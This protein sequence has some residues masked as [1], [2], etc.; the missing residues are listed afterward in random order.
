VI[1]ISVLVILN[2]KIIQKKGYMYRMPEILQKDLSVVSNWNLLK[3]LEGELC[4]KN[5][6]GCKF[7]TFLNKKIYI[8]GDSL[9]GTLIFN[10]KDK[11]TKRGYQYITSTFE[12]C[13][14]FLGTNQINLITN[15]EYSKCNNIYFQR[16]GKKLSDE[17]N[18]IIIFGGSYHFYNDILKG[19]NEKEEQ[20]LNSFRNEILK[21]SKN[22]KIILIYSIPWNEDHIPRKLKVFFDTLP[23]IVIKKIKVGDY[24]T[25][26]YEVY[27]SNTKSSFELLDSIQGDNIYRVYPHTLFCDTIIKKRCVTHDDKN[28][29]YADYNHPSIKGA[30]M[31]NDLIMKEIEKIELKSN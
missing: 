11:V 4:H 28:I 18:S 19:D 5:I 13:L 16:L 17:K 3:N 15:K 25:S 29:F 2:F 30:E 20:I 6:D 21:L 10:L 27:K 23:K 12:G 14:F 24:I 22:N 1:L 7:N 26:S 9:I 8:V 31:I